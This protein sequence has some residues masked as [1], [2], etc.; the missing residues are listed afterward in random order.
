MDLEPPLF[1]P[2]A[3]GLPCLFPQT[4]GVE[5]SAE[6]A[7]ELPARGIFYSWDEELT[8][9]NSASFVSPEAFDREHIYR[10][11]LTKNTNQFEVQYHE[12]TLEKSKPKITSY[13]QWNCKRSDV[14]G[15]VCTKLWCHIGKVW[16]TF[17]L[18]STLMSIE[19]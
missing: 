2:T 9:M 1:A 7:P 14:A 16:Q 8:A 18:C 17:K 10:Q 3:F 19:N 11:L 4:V 12:H 6:N 5:S 15:Y 13:V